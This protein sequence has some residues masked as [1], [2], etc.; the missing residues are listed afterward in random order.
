MSERAAIGGCLCGAI[1]VRA[2]GE[3]ECVLYCHC[4]D[5]R[6][7]TGAP[8]SIF[9]GYSAEQVEIE[10]GVPGSYESSPGVRRSFCGEC[11]TPLSY[12]DERL[13]GEVYLHA[14]IFDEPELFRPKLHGWDSQRLGWLHISD[15]L[16]RYEKSSKP[17]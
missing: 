12:E 5:C 9:A 8:V 15:D 3:P 4:S 17:R 13:P 6:K 11:G 2:T 14:G 16:P 1:K 10:R 7:A